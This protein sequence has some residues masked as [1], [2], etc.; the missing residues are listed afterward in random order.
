MSHRYIV[1]RK[2]SVMATPTATQAFTALE[3]AWVSL[4]ECW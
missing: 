2:S 3:R 4:L 1:T